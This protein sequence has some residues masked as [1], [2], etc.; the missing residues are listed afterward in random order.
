VPLTFAPVT[1]SRVRV[2]VDE[3]RDAMTFNYYANASSLLPV[4]I[5]ELG[6][7][8][9]VE[10]APAG[11]LA[12]ECRADL[13]TIDGEVVPVRITGTV[14]DA[15]AG[16]PLAIE[17][18]APA[19]DLDAGSHELRTAL[20]ID[21]GVQIDRLVLASD[22]GGE[23]LAVDG[24]QV[25]GLPDTPPPVPDVTVVDDGRT[26]MR[27]RVDGATEP[28]WLV[29]GQSASEGWTASTD[30]AQVG[31][32]RLVA[33]YANGWLMDPDSESLEVVLEWTPQRRVW[34][35][36]G[37]SLL[38]V[39]GCAVV[40]GFTWWRRR[41]KLAAATAPDAD[42]ARTQLAWPLAERL[43]SVSRRAQV[44]VPLG[45]GVLAAVAVTPWA[46]LVVAALV[47][48]GQRSRVGRLV[49]LL[50]PP[51]LVV[52]IG[53]YIAWSQRRYDIPPVFEWPTLFPRARTLAWLALLLAVGAVALDLPRSTSPNDDASLSRKDYG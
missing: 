53:V 33:G 38:G 5:A 30:G 49:L 10:P 28:F 36:L 24:G 39:I 20:G 2:V 18:C 47:A 11:E 1:G 50:A 37:L 6:I 31:E 8:G 34:A 4:G 46:G 35:A 52:L 44:L 16:N 14:P 40:V 12:G 26:R 42:D 17:S 29:L 9:L 27:V 21:T 22:V 45:V 3:I 25:T 23:P 32:R 51:A 43:P 15:V 19:I 41:G 48:F 7:P 13:L